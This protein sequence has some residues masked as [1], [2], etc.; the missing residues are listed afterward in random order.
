MWPFK[1]MRKLARSEDFPAL[2]DRVDDKLRSHGFK[3]E[4]DRLRKLVHRM[5]WT[6]SSELYQ[7]LVTA[8]KKI[9]K[10]SSG[11]PAELAAEIRRLIKSINQICRWR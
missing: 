5:A 1:D 2:I 9:R 8:L 3:A 4:A 7:E 6:T 10:E 11:L